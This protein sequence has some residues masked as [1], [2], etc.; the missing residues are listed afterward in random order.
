[1]KTEQLQQIPQLL[2]VLRIDAYST[3]LR[4]VDII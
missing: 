2:I 1:M 3:I 4:P